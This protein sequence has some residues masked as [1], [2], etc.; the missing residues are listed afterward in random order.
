MDYS[1]RV[2]TGVASEVG[3]GSRGALSFPC[4]GSLAAQGEQA[5]HGV[6]RADGDRSDVPIEFRLLQSML[7]AAE[8]L[9]EGRQSGTWSTA[10]Q[11]TGTLR[12]KASVA[13]LGAGRPPG[14][15]ARRKG[16]RGHVA[17]KQKVLG[18]VHSG[19]VDG[20][21]RPKYARESA[22]A[23]RRRSPSEVPKPVRC[24]GHPHES[25]LTGRTG[26]QVNR[27]TQIRDQERAPVASDLK[28][29]M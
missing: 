26:I 24:H 18:R 7:S 9:C 29:S 22:E 4:R 8:R 3:S 23:E 12:C 13:P 11:T 27:R 25:C 1:S 6:R 20:S 28:R 16:K 5:G 10:S 2:Y 17:E 14:V 15:P 21:G 19:G